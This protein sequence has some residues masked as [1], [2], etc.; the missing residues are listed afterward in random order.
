MDK[1]DYIE[2]NAGILDKLYL[3]AFNSLDNL[4]KESKQCVEIIEE[5]RRII[6]SSRIMVKEIN[7]IVSQLQELQVQLDGLLPDMK[8]IDDF[9]NVL[10]NLCQTSQNLFFTEKYLAS[11]DVGLF[12]D[13]VIDKSNF[14]TGLFYVFSEESYEKLV[15]STVD[16]ILLFRDEG[17]TEIYENNSYKKMIS[18]IK[19]LIQAILFIANR[20]LPGS[21]FFYEP[22]ISKHCRRVAQK[23]YDQLD[24]VTFASL[25]TNL[26]RVLTEAIEGLQNTERKFRAKPNRK[27]KLNSLFRTYDGAEELYTIINRA[28]TYIKKE[29]L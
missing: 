22:K 19:E 10:T 28:M 17:Y 12:G 20:I 3:P 13:D 15:S 21:M 14:P 16:L 4:L 29:N 1:I 18:K 25:L 8:S 23:L 24:Y 6:D 9:Y 27:I 11:V 5:I 2:K 26:Y 7:S